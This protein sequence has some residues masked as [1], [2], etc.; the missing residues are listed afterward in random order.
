MPRHHARATV[1]E[2]R[3]LAARGEIAALVRSLIEDHY[4]PAYRRGA[5]AP[6]LG[7]VALAALTAVDFARAADEVAR[8]LKGVS[9]AP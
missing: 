3:A 1:A 8:R 6:A 5:E 7:V 2:W 4:D 9:V